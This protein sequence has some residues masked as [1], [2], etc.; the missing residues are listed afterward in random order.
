[1]VR[2]ACIALTAGTVA[3]YAGPAAAQPLVVKASGLQV[4][5]AGYRPGATGL[6]GALDRFGP[7]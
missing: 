2:N 7:P 6:Q 4:T 1:M 5:L 3:A